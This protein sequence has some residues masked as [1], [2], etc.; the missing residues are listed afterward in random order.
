MRDVGILKKIFDWNRKEY[1][2]PELLRSMQCG[3]KIE[4]EV[5]A[6]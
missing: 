5:G 6:N 1:P 2:D 4:R 3:E